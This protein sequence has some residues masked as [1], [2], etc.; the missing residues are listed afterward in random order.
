[1]QIFNKSMKMRL[2]LKT[3]T[4]KF[5]KKVF[6]QIA[7]QKPVFSIVFTFLSQGGNNRESVPVTI[8]SNMNAHQALLFSMK[9]TT[10]LG[11]TQRS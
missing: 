3:G 8:V 2:F 5:I 7:G 11:D 10:L 1:M 9:V 4:L 6:F